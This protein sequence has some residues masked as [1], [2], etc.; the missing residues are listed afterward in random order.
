MGFRHQPPVSIIIPTYN[1]ARFLVRAIE[2]ARRQ[3]YPNVE[4]LIVD[5][6]SPDETPEVVRPF[7]H[8]P[9]VRYYRNEKNLGLV[10]NWRRG[11]ELARGSFCTFLCDDDL[12]APR[13]VESLIH[14]LLRDTS[15]AYAFSDIWMID[16]EGNLLLTRTEQMYRHSTR[17]HLAEGKIQDP[18][19]TILIN[20]SVFIGGVLFR[21]ACIQPDFFDERSRCYLDYWLFYQISRHHPSVWYHPER[22]VFLRMEPNGM[23]RSWKWRLYGLEGEIFLYRSL[24]EDPLYSPYR[25]ICMRRLAS[26]LTTYGNTLLTENR[27]EEARIALHNALEL[28][29]N[30]RA[31]AGYGLSYTGTLCR[32]L[33]Q[34]ARHIRKLFTLR[35]AS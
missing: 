3:T 30:I 33:V 29:K 28:Q 34:S 21:S 23:S 12:L 26:A 13:F 6:A 16:V 18:R 9:N 32:P 1:R 2:S 27:F 35:L 22:L 19:R 24:L 25:S 4:I 10:G 11:F 31:M 17:I 8:Y 7:L 20:R 15:L 14:P 5:D